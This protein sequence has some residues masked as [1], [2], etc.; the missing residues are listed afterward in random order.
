MVN[1]PLIEVILGR[2]TG[3]ST[4]EHLTEWIKAQ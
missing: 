3:N 4:E 1:K 2:E